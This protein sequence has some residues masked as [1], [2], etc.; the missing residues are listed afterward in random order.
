MLFGNMSQIGLTTNLLIGHAETNHGDTEVVSVDVSGSR[1][2]TDWRG[3]GQRCR[4]LASA[5]ENTGLEDGVRVGTIM[6]NNRSH[7]ELL[8]AISGFGG[9]AHTINPRLFPD[10][11]VYI[12]N[13]AQDRVL[14]VDPSYVG[15][16][17]GHKHL[18]ETVERFYITGPKQNEIAARMNGLE[19]LVDLLEEG[20]DSFQWPQ[21][22]EDAAAVLCYTSGT[23]GNPKGVLYSHKSIVLHAN[24]VSLPDSF[25]LSARDTILPIVPMFHVNAWGMTYASAMVGA[26]LILPGPNL[27]GKSIIRLMSEENVSVALAIPTIWEEVLEVLSNDPMPIRDLKRVVS[28][29]SAVPSWVI[30]DFKEKHGVHVQQAW[31]MTE[32][33]PLG[34]A[35]TPLGKHTDLEHDQSIELMENAGR[36][37]W[38]VEIRI[39]NDSGEEIERGGSEGAIQVR[40]PTVI[41]RYL[42]DESDAVDES[43]WFETGDLGVLDSDGFLT[44]T[45]RSKDLIKSGGEW[46]SSIELEEIIKLHPDVYDAAVI[47]VKH[48]KWSERPI[49]IAEMV[50]GS[51]TGQAELLDFYDGKVVKWQKPDAVVFVDE[52]PLG[53][54][55][56]PIKRELREE[57]EDYL[58]EVSEDGK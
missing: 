51:R 49:V 41:R 4:K 26:R 24:I 53:S 48:D 27:D 8:Y 12:I 57:Y 54:T 38:A 17:I 43:G 37:N 9:V 42:F 35:N 20:D 25:C 23:T 29:G 7:L 55:G 16:L 19:F 40:G 13:H 11:I 56:K 46:I 36:T 2:R 50:K 39:I 32:T 44:I 10:E 28:G 31:G 15:F 33:S 5:L 58:L 3:I 1:E 18:L 52:L 30:R 34:T 14:F 21:L 45:D 6:P 47:G 22:D